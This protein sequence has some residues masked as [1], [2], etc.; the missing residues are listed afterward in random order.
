MTQIE[1]GTQDL[2]AQLDEGVATVTLNRPER[3][4]ALSLPLLEALAEVLGRCERD[5]EVRVVVLTGAGS[6]FCAGGDVKA[7]AGAGGGAAA[8]SSF[9]ERVHLQRRLQRESVARMYR[10]PKPVIASLPGAAAGAG[11]G[12]CLAA[13]LRIASDQAVMLTAFAR[14]G[15]SGDYG[16]PW[17]LARQVGRA[18]ALELFY[19][20]DKLDAQ[21]CLQLGLVNQ[22]VPADQLSARTR[23]LARRLAAG[24]RAAYGYIKQNVTGALEQSLEAFMDDEVLRHLSA[25]RTEDHREAAQ[26]FVDKRAPVFK[27]R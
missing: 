16:A 21:Q 9:A 3:R 23:E 10:M 8:S 19:L 1:T 11:L 26:A 18:K 24:P 13:D 7:M 2:L 6:A 22:L 27:G 5:A 17:L 15:L 14:V 4:N 25:Q 20:S 12:L